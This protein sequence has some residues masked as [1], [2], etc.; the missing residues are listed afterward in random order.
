MIPDNYD[1]FSGYYGHAQ[2]QNNG[3]Q[4]R[5]LGSLPLIYL[6]A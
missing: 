5:E 3:P 4:T 2:T 1:L 6:S